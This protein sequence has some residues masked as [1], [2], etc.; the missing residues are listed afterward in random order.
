VPQVRAAADVRQSA[1][2]G[3]RLVRSPDVDVHSMRRR[4]HP[5]H[6]SRRAW[7]KLKIV[8]EL[9]LRRGQSLFVCSYPLK[10]NSGT[11]VRFGTNHQK[12][13]GL[14]AIAANLTCCSSARL[15][16]GDQPDM[17]QECGMMR[18]LAVDKTLTPAQLADIRKS[19]DKAGCS[20]IF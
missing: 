20:N 1:N 17:S 13:L 8:A 9:C 2:A 19:M 16:P 7:P 5:N 12:M 14:V 10:A 6:R 11:A 15:T 18:Q 3:R 4:N